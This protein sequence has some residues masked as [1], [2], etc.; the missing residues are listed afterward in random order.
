MFHVTE[1]RELLS[2]GDRIMFIHATHEWR[3]PVGLWEVRGR[4]SDDLWDRAYG[5]VLKLEKRR[6]L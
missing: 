1:E 5:F 3:L 6:N 2:R 4:K